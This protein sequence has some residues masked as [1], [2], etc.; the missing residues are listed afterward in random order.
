MDTFKKPHDY[1]IYL[2]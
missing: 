2:P 1:I